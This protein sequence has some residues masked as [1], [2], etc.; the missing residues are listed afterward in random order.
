MTSPWRV[1][2]TADFRSASG[3][4]LFD[5]AALRILDAAANIEWEIIPEQTPAV[6]PEQAAKYDA[7]MILG[8]GVPAATLARTDL[9]LRHVAR[10]GVGFE[11]IDLNACN[12]AGVLVTITPDGVRRPVAMM[13]LTFILA[14]AQH[15]L[16]KDRLTRTGRWHER[17]NWMGKGLGG[18]TLGLVGLGNTGRDLA[19]LI[20]PFEMRVIAA[21]PAVSPADAAAIGV[22]LKAPDDVLRE[23]DF[24]SL[25]LPLT[26][27]TRGFIG[28]RELSLMRADAYLIN[29]ARGAVVDQPALTRAL[30]RGRIAGAGLDVFAVEPVPPD[31]PLLALDNVVL[32]PHSLCWTDEC[33]RGCAES[34]LRAIVAIAE[35][36]RPEYVVNPEAF[37]HSHHRLLKKAPQPFSQDRP[38]PT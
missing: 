35:G 36:K 20:R 37:A 29:T 4:L 21:D 3:T 22:E 25:H 24:V 13:A 30:A 7:I 38:A 5:E 10:F 33:W 18:R 26:P 27:A 28:D 16:T 31:D 8:P 1:G 15:L 32:A 14:L 11:I 34:A 6:T 23:S 9:R 2:L 12:R 17:T 19:R